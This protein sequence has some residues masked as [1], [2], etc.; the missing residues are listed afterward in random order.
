MTDRYISS[1]PSNDSDASTTP[2]T[3]L[4][5]EESWNPKWVLSTRG[6]PLTTILR[7]KASH[8]CKCLPDT[9]KDIFSFNRSLGAKL[10]LGEIAELPKVNVC[11]CAYSLYED[12]LPRKLTGLKGRHLFEDLETV[13]Q[14]VMVLYKGTYWT[15]RVTKGDDLTK[16]RI[17]Q[18][19]SGNK[20]EKSTTVLGKMPLSKQGVAH[21]RNLLSTVDGCAIQICLAFPDVPQIQNW[22]YFDNLVNCMFKNMLVDW[23]LPHGV[24]YVSFY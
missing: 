13:N 17:F 12:L 11:W 23:T 10:F 18:L 20:A 6:F 1:E 24:E 15:H 9:H 8:R 19:L 3:P 4:Q 14:A 21:L 5:K 22:E 2:A 16:L 7:I